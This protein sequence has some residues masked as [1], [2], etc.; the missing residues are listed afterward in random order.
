MVSRNMVSRNSAG[1]YNRP[2]PFCALSCE[3]LNTLKPQTSPPVGQSPDLVQLRVW[4]LTPTPYT[5]HV[6]RPA[7]HRTHPGPC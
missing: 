6:L 7:W 1:G 5:L 3:T 4:F 2:I